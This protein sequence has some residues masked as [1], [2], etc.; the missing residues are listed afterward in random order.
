MESRVESPGRGFAVA[1]LLAYLV[2][3]TGIVLMSLDYQNAIGN[4]GLGDWTLRGAIVVGGAFGVPLLLA[5]SACV[6]TGRTS[7]ILRWLSAGS[8]G[9][10]V[11]FFAFGGGIF[12]IP[13]A[14]LM[15]VSAILS[16]SRGGRSSV[17][18]AHTDVAS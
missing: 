12:F 14:G 17:S 8:L 9:L 4:S 15:V 10:L 18:D 13:A 3:T 7:T 6:A 2:A 5:T 1:A 16:T 11:L